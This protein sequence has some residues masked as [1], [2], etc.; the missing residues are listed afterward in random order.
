EPQV[1]EPTYAHK[2]SSDDRRLDWSRPAEELHRVV[3][4]GGAWTTFRGRRL[5]VLDAVIDASDRDDAPADV[6][7]VGEL[8]GNR[9][10]TGE[11]A[12]RLVTV[13]P[14]GKGPIAAHDWLNGAHPEPGERLGEVDAA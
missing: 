5:K 8:D 1:G 6:A 9:V 13:Q 7:A 4:V 14:E 12:L 3:R 2:L 10:T 11:G